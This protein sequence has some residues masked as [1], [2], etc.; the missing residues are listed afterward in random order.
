MEVDPSDGEEE[1]AGCK[2]GEE[3]EEEED[4]STM[5]DEF[6]PGFQTLEDYSKV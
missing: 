2:T 1:G 4:E 5:V 6:L 3:E